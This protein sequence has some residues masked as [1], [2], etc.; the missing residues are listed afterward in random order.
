LNEICIANSSELFKVS[1]C[2]YGTGKHVTLYDRVCN[3]TI[4]DM[5]N[6]LSSAIPLFVVIKRRT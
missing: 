1:I 2:G 6:N 3:I 5:D 4:P